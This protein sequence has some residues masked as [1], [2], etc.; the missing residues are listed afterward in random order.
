M[1]AVE[2]DDLTHAAA[3]LLGAALATIATLRIVRHIAVLF[4][5]DRYRRLRPDPPDDQNRAG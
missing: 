4:G 1:V 3:F 5:G 2:W